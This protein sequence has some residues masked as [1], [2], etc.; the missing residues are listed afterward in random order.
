[1]RLRAVE[2]EGAMTPTMVAQRRNQRCGGSVATREKP[3]AVAERLHKG[4]T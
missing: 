3:T 1:V 2:L 4:T